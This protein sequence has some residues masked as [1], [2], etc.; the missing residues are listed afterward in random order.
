[1]KK[2]LYIIDE[3][4]TG[5]L[6]NSNNVIGIASEI[7]DRHQTYITLLDG[8][9]VRNTLDG[10]PAKNTQA[11]HDWYD[12]VLELNEEMHSID[13]LLDN[14]CHAKRI[15]YIPHH[16]AKRLLQQLQ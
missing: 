11:D 8:T 2:F 4:L 1:M 7:K 10:S 16:I 9:E 5:S 15:G 13:D 14:L 3:S 6:P 12:E